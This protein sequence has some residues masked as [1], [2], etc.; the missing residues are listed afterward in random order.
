MLPRPRRSWKETIVVQS[1]C[2]CGAVNLVVARAPTEITECNCTMCRRY[3]SRMA[4]FSPKEV[5]ITGAT[6]FYT[7]GDKTIELHR[8]RICGCFTHWSPIDKAY[9]RM[10]VNCRMMEPSVLEG[11]RVRKL[12]GLDTWKYL[13]E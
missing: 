3:G 7:H 9:D 10:G 4:Y 11:V 13:D 1:S 5:E 12:D 2:H 8:C 6:D